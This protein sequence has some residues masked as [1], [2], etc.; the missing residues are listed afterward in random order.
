MVCLE[1]EAFL[2]VNQSFGTLHGEPPEPGQ[3]RAQV[4]GESSINLRS[5][6]E[7]EF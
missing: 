1:N 4:D 6:R 2:G 3:P 5:N 7:S